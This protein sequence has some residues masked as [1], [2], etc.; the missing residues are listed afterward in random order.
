[1]AVRFAYKG[2]IAGFESQRSPRKA[3]AIESRV[4]VFRY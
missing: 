3:Q 1:V 4:V 2:S